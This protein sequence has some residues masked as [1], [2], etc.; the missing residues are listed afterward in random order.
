MQERVE[1][2]RSKKE[3]PKSTSDPDAHDG[4]KMTAKM[5][6]YAVRSAGDQLRWGS[7]P[8]TAKRPDRMVGR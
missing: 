5:H 6:F 2:S 4:P 3:A 8:S 1:E 7:A